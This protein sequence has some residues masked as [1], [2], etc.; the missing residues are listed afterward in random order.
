MLTFKML[1]YTL[2]VL[3]SNRTAKGILWSHLRRSGRKTLVSHL[4]YVN[5]QMSGE[6]MVSPFLILSISHI[7]NKHKNIYFEI[8]YND[9]TKGPTLPS[10][11]QRSL[12][13]QWLAN[14]IGGIISTSTLNQAKLAYFSVFQIKTF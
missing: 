9:S 5:Y 7:T 3:S 12:Q 6:I 13:T 2:S 8:F 10:E 11:P 1:K 4:L 14:D